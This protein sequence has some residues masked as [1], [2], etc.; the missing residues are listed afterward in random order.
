M[1]GRLLIATL[2]LTFGLAG[3]VDVEIIVGPGPNEAQERS[4]FVAAASSICAD[5]NAV[6]QR[7]P[8]AKTRA[9]ALANVSRAADAERAA[10]DRL[11]AIEPPAS[12]VSDMSSFLAAEENLLAATLNWL[13][14]RRNGAT[15]ALAQATSDAAVAGRRVTRAA[16]RLG[17][18]NC[19]HG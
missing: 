17:L 13:A 10:I 11:A 8:R 12:M 2:V 18:K 5:R 16:R 4:G 15:V 9:Q 1:S 19:S 3:C 7:L 6:L 14:A